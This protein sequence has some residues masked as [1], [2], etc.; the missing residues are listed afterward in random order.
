MG[1]KLMGLLRQVVADD[2]GQGLPALSHRLLIATPGWATARPYTVYLAPNER[3]EFLVTCREL[4]GIT[5]FGED[6]EEALAMAEQAI[7]EAV[8]APRPSSDFPD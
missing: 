4:P 1:R 8:G 3:G 2:D 7:R 5:T 6:E